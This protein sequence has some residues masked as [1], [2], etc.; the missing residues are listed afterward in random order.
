M[1]L[2]D[3][4]I[5]GAIFGSQVVAMN[6]KD[7]I[8]W[9]WSLMRGLGKNGSNG[10]GNGSARWNAQDHDRIARVELNQDNAFDAIKASLGNIEG[11][12]KD[13]SNNT[14]RLVTLA[15]AAVKKG[16]S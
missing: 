2:S 16:Q 15:D 10:N 12:I 7:V 11:D 3:G 4:Q 13:V 9:A 6:A 5:L 14:L 1:A 8:G